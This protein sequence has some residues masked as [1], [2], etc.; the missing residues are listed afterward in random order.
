M[1]EPLRE[2]VDGLSP[3]DVQLLVLR[4]ELYDG[5]WVEMQRDL[6]ARRSGKPF[7]FALVNKIEEDL[8]R[9]E[10]LSS[11]EARFQVDLADYV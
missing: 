8:E 6:Q 5:S 3:A 10:R 11:F 1:N 4:D 9:I 2:F 7:I